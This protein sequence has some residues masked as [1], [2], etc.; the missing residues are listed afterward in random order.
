MSVHVLHVCLGEMCQQMLTKLDWFGTLFPR[1][2]VPVEKKIYE[3]L[4]EWR[5]QQRAAAEPSAPEVAAGEPTQGAAASVLAPDRPAAAAGQPP[6]G[7]ALA[8]TTHHSSPMYVPPLLIIYSLFPFQT[9]F[10]NLS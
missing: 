9:L 5:Q 7:S 3:K 2:P 8:G 4:A 1:I 10:K 6:S